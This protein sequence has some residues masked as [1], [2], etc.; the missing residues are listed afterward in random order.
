MVAICF[1]FQVHQPFR[2]KQ[3]KIFDIGNDDEY[4]DEKLNAEIM[5]K[6]ANKCYLP[7]NK[8][9]LDL[10][11]MHKGNFKCAFSISGVAI[12]QMEKYAPHVLES[13]KEL[14]RT[15]CVKRQRISRT[16]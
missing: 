9:L 6:V 1:Y 13:F 4:F 10:I 7:M 11:H 12:E 16:W 2:I 14:A 8:V 5:E 15:G 3:Y